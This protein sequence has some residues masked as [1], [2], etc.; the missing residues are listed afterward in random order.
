[1]KDDRLGLPPAL[2]ADGV[3]PTDAG[4][5]QMVPIVERAIAAA[6]A[7]PAPTGLPMPPATASLP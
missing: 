7:A 6:L 2:A 1:M 5:R 4:Y 3:H